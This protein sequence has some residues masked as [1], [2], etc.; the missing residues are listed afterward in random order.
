MK[1]VEIEKKRSQ[2]AEILES[3]SSPRFQLRILVDFLYQ[4]RSRTRFDIVRSYFLEFSSPFYNLISDHSMLH[5][6]PEFMI[7]IRE[8]IDLYMTHFQKEIDETR[9]TQCR[10]SVNYMLI[11]IWLILGEWGKAIEELTTLTG[12]TIPD[13]SLGYLV[14]HH[15]SYEQSS[16]FCASMQEDCPKSQAICRRIQDNWELDYRSLK[17]DRMHLLF[18][19]N[20]PSKITSD[21]N[22]GIMLPLLVKT[23][24]RPRD[25]EEDLVKFNNEVLPT[26]GEFGHRVRDAVSAARSSLETRRFYRVTSKYYY[27]QFSMPDKSPLFEG[28]SWGCA[29]A[30]MAHTA[31]INTYFQQHLHAVNSETVINGGVDL[32]GGLLPVNEEGLQ[33][34]IRT[35]FFSPIKRLIIPWNNMAYAMECLEILRRRYP[36]RHLILESAENLNQL[37][38]DRNLVTR[39]RLTPARRLTSSLRRQKGKL[40]WALSGLLLIFLVFSINTRGRIWIDR[41]P[42]TYE[43]IGQYLIVRNLEGKDLWKY[44]FSVPLT[45]QYY[46]KPAQNVKL[47]NIDNDEKYEVLIGIYEYNHPETSGHLFVFDNEGSLMLKLKTGREITF[48]KR[49]YADHYR[50]AY[51]DVVD[52]ESDGKKELVTISHHFPDFPCCV[53]IWDLNGNKLSEYW[54]AG[55]IDRAYFFDLDGDGTSEMFLLGQNNEYRCAVLAVLPPQHHDGISPQSETGQYYTKDIPRAREIHYIRF[56][57]SD[58]IRVLGGNDQAYKIQKQNNRYQVAIANKKVTDVRDL[59]TAN[60]LYY[61]F[62]KNFRLENLIISNNYK[63]AYYRAT[64]QQIDIVQAEER[65]SRLLYYDGERWS[66]DQE[67]IPHLDQGKKLKD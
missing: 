61:Y 44:D 57:Q 22:G 67:T 17:S 43:I 60:I 15:D 45:R 4:I 36:R 31:M 27:F 64:G 53:N 29:L 25:A 32:H 52:V 63:Q 11:R 21:I 12:E 50:I 1:I 40:A 28:D 24:I 10:K 49:S 23:R 39:K 8:L 9:L 16:V 20:T 46:F 65:L 55:H 56:P 5:T 33:A 66:Y 19:E 38:Q 54:H 62:N 6:D 37:V 30:V 51:V 41:N 34:K 42:A 13:G 2:I 18:V 35:A 26:S 58:I 7:Q 3:P 47:K 48:G 14:S 59:E